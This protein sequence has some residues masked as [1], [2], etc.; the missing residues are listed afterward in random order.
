M[1][2]K[3]NKRLLLIFSYLLVGF[4]VVVAV[5]A[6]TGPTQNPSGGNPAWP[7]VNSV[8]GTDTISINSTN[9]TDMTGMSY[10][11]TFAAGNVVVQFKSFGYINAPAPVHYHML[12]LKDGVVVDRSLQSDAG[13]ISTSYVDYTT[14]ILTYV[15]PVTAGTHT[16]KVQWSSTG[17]VYQEGGTYPRTLWIIRGLN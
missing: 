3:F 16:F 15:G 8:V 11:D 5:K 17:L 10:T 4:L 9:D 12:L 6:F 1:K 14:I 7:K 2:L 13:N